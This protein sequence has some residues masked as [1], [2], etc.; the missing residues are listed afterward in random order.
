MQDTQRINYLISAASAQVGNDA[1]LAEKLG[2]SRQVL[3]DWR[4]GRKS[5]SVAVQADLAAIGGGDPA[6]VVLY[7]L[8]EDAE[9]ERKKRLQGAL[10]LLQSNKTLEEWRRRS[11][12]NR[13]RQALKRLQDSIT[14]HAPTARNLAKPTAPQGCQACGPAEQ[15]A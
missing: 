14:H 1:Q 4:H 7:A 6:K 15:P 3:S 11:L 10:Q 9:G 8:I 13:L 2:T 5:P 12:P